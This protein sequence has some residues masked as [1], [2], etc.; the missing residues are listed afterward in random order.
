MLLKKDSIVLVFLLLSLIV[1]SNSATAQTAKGSVVYGDYILSYSHWTEQDGMPSWV[2][3]SI[4]QDKRGYLWFLTPTGIF[5]FDGHFFKEYSLG[6]YRPGD[7]VVSMAIDE[8]DRLWLLVKAPNTKRKILLLNTHTG[9]LSD[10]SVLN[11][12]TSVLKNVEYFTATQQGFDLQTYQK[13]VWRYDGTWSLKTTLACESCYFLPASGG[14]FWI[15]DLNRTYLKLCN[16]DGIVKDYSDAGLDYYYYG[17][18]V[19]NKT[20]LWACAYPFYK[21]MVASKPIYITEE[22]N[23]DSTA[24]D[25]VQFD[26][27]RNLNHNRLWFSAKQRGRFSFSID[28]NP[29]LRISYNAKKIDFDI[30]TYLKEKYDLKIDDEHL[31]YFPENEGVVWI[32]YTGGMLRLQLKQLLFKTYKEFAGKSVRGIYASNKYSVVNTNEAIYYTKG[33]PHSQPVVNVDISA[34]LA[35]DQYMGVHKRADTIWVAKRNH[36]A[37]FLTES[38]LLSGKSEIG[39]YIN[40]QD[41]YSYQFSED[42][43]GKLLLNTDWG[44]AA[45]NHLE[46][47]FLDYA[48]KDTHVYFSILHKDTLFASTEM[49][50]VNLASR[51]LYKIKSRN[52]STIR[53]VYIHIDAEGY[54][55]LTSDYGL[56]RWKPG[57]NTVRAYKS[58]YGLPDGPIYACL[59][60]NYGRMW[61][62][63]N[64][65][66]YVLD[67]QKGISFSYD[68]ADGLPDNECNMTSY[69][70]S[71]DGRFYIGTINGLF[72]FHPDRIPSP[73]DE[74]KNVHIDKINVV[75]QGKGTVSLLNEYLETGVLKI[76]QKDKQVLIGFSSPSFARQIR[77]YQWRIPSIS[78]TWEKTSDSRISFYDLP[79]GK[80]TLEIIPLGAAAYN[81]DSKK[82][83]SVPIVMV[84]PF[85]YSWPFYLFIALAVVAITSYVVKWRLSAT[86]RRNREL[87]AVVQEKTQELTFQNTQIAKQKEEIERLYELKNRFL[88][89]INH[90]LRTPLTIIKGYI[91]Q[92]KSGEN[93]DATE[94][95]IV[96]TIE[97]NADQLYDLTED[98]LELTRMDS[99]VVNIQEE[100]I[101]L[102]SFIQLLFSNFEGLAVKK[103]IDYRLILNLHQNDLTLLL[104]R[105]KI[106]KILNNLITNAIKFTPSGGAIR[107]HCITNDANI[108]FKVED[109]G[110]GISEEDLIHIFDR[111]FQASQNI[112][113]TRPGFGIGLSLCKEYAEV[114]GGM[115]DVVSIPGK[116]SEFTLTLPLKR[117][118][119][120]A[121][122][123]PKKVGSSA[124]SRDVLAPEKAHIR[125]SA[126]LL[127]A[128]DSE[129]LRQY[130]TDVLGRHYQITAVEDGEMAW[131]ILSK[132][133]AGVDLIISDI[134]MPRMDGKAL[135]S[136]VRETSSLEGMPFIFLTALADQEGLISALNIGVDSYVTKPFDVVELTARIN[137]LL[138][139]KKQRLLHIAESR[140]IPDDSAK[141][142]PTSVNDL[143]L[144]QL[145]DIIDQKIKFSDLKVDDLAQDLFVSE[146]TFRNKIKACSGLSPSEYLLKYRL[147]KA[148][149]LLENK[150]HNTVSEVCYAVGFKNTSHFARV[151]KEEYGKSPSEYLS[152]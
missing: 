151:F 5:R 39:T 122:T 144:K 48:L 34:H 62:P 16:A 101:Q 78:K 76:R 150:A 82:V 95:R 44:I 106:E 136:K 96:D 53:V 79:Y 113:Q 51:R 52:G 120:E 49:G 25:H 147:R 72:S 98:V 74:V 38:E 59:Q 91:Q 139:Y 55:W 15:T 89:H 143:W 109:T 21:D 70:K 87:N 117:S 2:V 80:H 37:L 13:E 58:Q 69:F 129:D 83:L 23:L 50:I 17:L 146:R 63:S 97:R 100:I 134:M 7:D 145:N 3:K 66:L 130:L 65:G 86:E 20:R 4:I 110:A 111:Y 56:Y 32:R 148:L 68:K 85:Y 75:R 135:L 138:S 114:M 81:F 28:H 26:D 35:Y 54:F 132:E 123:L 127:I 31:L 1:L 47:K 103:D 24:Y 121:S 22:G 36:G 33:L 118:I 41:G 67:L 119:A 64:L 57:S 43:N 90:E 116:G 102:Y 61:L 137:N 60:D 14:N 77:G 46:N 42:K 126:H 73:I 11:A 125:T 10:L 124:T 12:P 149:L 40:R 6:R 141:E 71:D 84:R 108:H 131:G 19:D 140:A 88:G 29:F 112:D 104:D 94:N 92:L 30:L 142:V 133:D 152:S 27:W 105:K 128:E 8:A 93:R 9:E 45:Y 18:F 115:I 99:G 107:L